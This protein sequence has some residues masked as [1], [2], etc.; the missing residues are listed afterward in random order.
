MIL[1]IGHQES[2]V[3]R[4]P[5]VSFAIIVACVVAFMATDMERAYELADPA[6]SHRS[7]IRS[8]AGG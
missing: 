5:W 3:R 1:P 2:S 6:Y 7:T 8:C 4:L